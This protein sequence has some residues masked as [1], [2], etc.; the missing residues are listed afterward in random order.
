[1]VTARW[2]LNPLSAPKLEFFGG[3]FFFPVAL[4]LP[5]HP[6]VGQNPLPFPLGF[7]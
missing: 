6:S 1:M 5:L 3:K 4:P 7:E 2:K